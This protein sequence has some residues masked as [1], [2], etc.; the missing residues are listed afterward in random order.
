MVRKFTIFFEEFIFIVFVHQFEIA[1]CFPFSKKY[2]FILSFVTNMVSDD[3][4]FWPVIIF[5][6]WSTVFK[7]R[8]ELSSLSREYTEYSFFMNPS[9]PTLKMLILKFL[10]KIAMHHEWHFLKSYGGPWPFPSQRTLSML[11]KIMI[12]LDDP[13]VRDLP[14]LFTCSDRSDGSECEGCRTK[15]AR[16]KRCQQ[17]AWREQPGE[18]NVSVIPILRYPVNM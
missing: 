8:P 2:I 9:F 17:V 16:S 7:R 14:L 3:W 18:I 1:K 6:T 12:I 13:L 5:N 10:L 15:P 4:F 11:V